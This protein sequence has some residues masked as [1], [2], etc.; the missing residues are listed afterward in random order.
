MNCSLEIKRIKTDFTTW[1]YPNQLSFSLI[2]I[3]SLV[4]G[5]LAYNYVPYHIGVVYGPFSVLALAMQGYKT[6]YLY[7][8]FTLFTWLVC[9]LYEIT[10]IFII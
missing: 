1:I 4:V 10:Q 7:H 8:P 2:V 3:T 5:A 9:V 6:E